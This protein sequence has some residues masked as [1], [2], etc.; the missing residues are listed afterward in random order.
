[1]FQNY[2]IFIAA[3]KYIKY[4]SGTT[5]ID[6]CKSN[7][8]SKESIKNMIKL[9]D[10]FMPTFVDHHVLSDKNFK[11]HCLRNNFIMV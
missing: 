5:H 9:D 8:I 4:F 11:G 1:M 3:K 2:F 7:G 10:N 6:S